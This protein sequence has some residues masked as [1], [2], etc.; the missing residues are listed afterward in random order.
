MAD[1]KGVKERKME[2]RV[3]GDSRRKRMLVE[4]EVVDGWGS[5]L[6]LRLSQEHPR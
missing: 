6:P 5:Q 3:M 4:V 1:V 2:R